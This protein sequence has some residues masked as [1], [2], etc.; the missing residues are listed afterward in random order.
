[1][2]VMIKVLTD[3]NTYLGFQN[4]SHQPLA[5]V[6]CQGKDIK[7]TNL[8]LNRDWHKCAKHVLSLNQDLITDSDKRFISFISCWKLTYHNLVPSAFPFQ[9][10][11]GREKEE[12]SAGNEVAH[13]TQY[14]SNQDLQISSNLSQVVRGNNS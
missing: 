12:K 4:C 1:M 6:Q 9:K 2:N 7:I 8:F 13:I 5:R 10:G 14:L 3:T 11:K